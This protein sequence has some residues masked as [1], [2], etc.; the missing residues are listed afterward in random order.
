MALPT[1]TGAFIH[2][3][4]NCSP[5]V[6]P[7]A[8]SIPMS[9]TDS[10]PVKSVLDNLS[11]D[12]VAYD[13]TSSAIGA[14]TVQAAIDAIL[15]RIYPVGSVYLS[16]TDSDASMVSARFGGTWVRIAEGE[17]LFG[18]KS[19]DTDFG[20]VGD[21]GGSRA[22]NLQHNHTLPETDGTTLTGAQSGIAKHSHGLNNHYHTYDKPK[23]NVTDGHTLKTTEIPAHSHSYGKDGLYINVVKG[24]GSYAYLS[25]GGSSGWVITSDGLSTANAGGGGSHSHGIS[26]TSTST[27]GNTGS[28]TDAG[29]TDAA[30]AHSHTF[31]NKT[32]GNGLSSTQNI[33]NPYITVYIYK[34][35]A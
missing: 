15:D 23:N 9:P 30:Q 14:N 22:V 21:E 24:S 1:N 25:Q 7:T 31:T 13:D 6:I 4:V 5:N 35:T 19:G 27:G 33:L 18:Y 11:A 20:T 8:Q 34:R 26:Y 3:G 16:F 29:N 32:T 2:N 28:T 10:T 17:T 12:D